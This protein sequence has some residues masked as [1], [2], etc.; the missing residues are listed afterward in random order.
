MQSEKEGG[1]GRKKMKEGESLRDREEG[2]RIEQG[3]QRRENKEF[4]RFIKITLSL[5]ST[6]SSICL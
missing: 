4:I 3:R 1:R 6:H 5:Q 2:E